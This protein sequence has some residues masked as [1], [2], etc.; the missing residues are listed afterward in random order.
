MGL[1][2]TKNSHLLIKTS[3]WAHKTFPVITSYQSGDARYSASSDFHNVV[4]FAATMLKFSILMQIFTDILHDLKSRYHLPERQSATLLFH[5]NSSHEMVLADGTDNYTPTKNVILMEEQL[6]KLPCVFASSDDA[7]VDF[8]QNLYYDWQGNLKEIGKSVF[9][10]F[11]WGW[12]LAVRKKF[13]KIGVD[14]S[15][16]PSTQELQDIRWFASRQFH[17][18]YIRLFL[19]QNLSVDLGASLV[20]HRMSFIK[21]KDALDF[22]GDSMIFK[23]NWSSSGRGNF[24]AQQ[25]DEK[26]IKRINGFIRTQGGCLVDKCYDKILDFAM[27]FYIFANSEV[28]FVGF[29]VFQTSENGK[30]VGNVVDSQE[31]I[32]MLIEKHF[33]NRQFIDM[34]INTHCEILKRTMAGRYTGFVGIDMM[35]VRED[36]KTK[37]HPCVEINPRMNMGILAIA[38]YLRPFFFNEEGGG[39]SVVGERR[40]SSTRTPSAVM[41]ERG[42]HTCLRDRFISIKYS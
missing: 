8:Y 28:R 32:R 14:Q 27:E 39:G 35:A 3:C 36:G 6:A 29:S 10:P 5:F 41:R 11:P 30:Y 37:C 42:F 7:V 23:Q 21:F 1:K 33:E 24:T 22:N 34:L 38:A 9:I 16:M 26:T 31:N 25:A 18:D 19:F 17:V 4:F 20:G 12:N 13:L 15:Y 2:T 40:R